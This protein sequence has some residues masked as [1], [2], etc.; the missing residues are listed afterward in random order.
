MSS[1]SSKSR[2]T[3]STNILPVS[4]IHIISSTVL[5]GFILQATNHLKAVTLM[6][7]EVIPVNAG[8]A[9]F[10]KNL[11]FYSTFI[12]PMLHLSWYKFCSLEI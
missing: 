7:T 3:V 8:E 12:L 11:Q 6:A 9:Y 5:Y 4:S 10:N 2:Y 1:A